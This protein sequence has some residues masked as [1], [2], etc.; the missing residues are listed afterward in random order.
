MAKFR[1]VNTDFW[2]TPQVVDDFNATD[3]YLYLYLLT[4]PHANLCGCYEISIRQ[5]AAETDLE[6]DIVRATLERLEVRHQ[7]TEYQTKTKEI[8]ILN[9]LRNGWTGSPKWKKRIMLEIGKIK[10]D[11]FRY[12][13]RAQCFELQDK[14]SIAKKSGVRPRLRTPLFR[15]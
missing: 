3:R 14:A 11:G 4:N 9:G 6:R 8:L 1:S 10:Y 7:V 2:H 13:I 15:P 5:I 12:F